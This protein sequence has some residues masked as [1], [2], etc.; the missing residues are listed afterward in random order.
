MTYFFC[1]GCSIFWE[2][3]N[4][5][6]SCPMCFLGNRLSRTHIGNI[7]GFIELTNDRENQGTYQKKEMRI[8]AIAGP[9]EV[10]KRRGEPEQCYICIENIESKS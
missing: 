8:L 10:E 1:W 5:A 9:V 4:D 3:A 7:E 2:L 6:I